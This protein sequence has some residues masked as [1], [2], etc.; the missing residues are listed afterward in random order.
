[1]SASRAMQC[2]AMGIFFLIDGTSSMIDLAI[3][4]LLDGPS[5]ETSKILINSVGVIS[6]MI[7]AMVLLVVLEKRWALGL[8]EA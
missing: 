5:S 6:T 7:I 1:M 4:N 3:L 2:T 8:R